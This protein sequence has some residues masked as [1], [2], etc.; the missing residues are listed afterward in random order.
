MRL[1]IALTLLLTAHAAHASCA[2]SL[3][4]VDARRLTGAPEKLCEIYAGKVVL[5]VNTASQCGYTPQYEGLEKL[6]QKYRSQGLVVLGFPSDEFGGQEPGSDAEIAKF[7]KV[8]FGVQFPMFAKGSVKG[9]NAQALYQKL[10]AASGEAPRWNF[11]KYLLSR[12]GQFVSV[13]PSKVKPDD[14]AL[15]ATIETQLQKSP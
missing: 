5:V 15:L 3:L 2:G 11:H 9:D 8:N 1:L 14:A 4:E 10:I 7:C 13:Y 12:D 6:Y